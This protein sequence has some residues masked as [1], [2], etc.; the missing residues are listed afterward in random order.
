MITNIGEY[1]DCGS[2][3]LRKDKS[4]NA[5]AE[6]YKG[7]EICF[8]LVRNHSGRVGVHNLNADTIIE[9]DFTKSILP[10]YSSY[11]LIFKNTSDNISLLILA[12]WNQIYT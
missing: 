1:H 9:Q 2:V 10:K 6:N 7:K 11:H 5:P 12:N 8:C 3:N 4:L